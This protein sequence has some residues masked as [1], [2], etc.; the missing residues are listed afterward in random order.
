MGMRAPLVSVYLHPL[1]ANKE[2]LNH[3]Q[4]IAVFSRIS[5]FFVNLM[6]T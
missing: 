3:Q 5:K 4:E 1:V 2:N 6:Q